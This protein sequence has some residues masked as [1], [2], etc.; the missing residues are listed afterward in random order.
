MFNIPLD[1]RESKQ[2]WVPTDVHFYG[3]KN[4]E[5]FETI[6]SRDK[7]LKLVHEAY[8]YAQKINIYYATKDF[9]KENIALIERKLLFEFKPLNT[10]WGT[11]TDPD[12][13]V[14]LIHDGIIKDTI[15][16]WIDDT[17][18]YKGFRSGSLRR[19]SAN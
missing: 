2:E 10:Y 12:S 1:F 14:T 7:F 6:F 11:K 15:K 16:K 18:D 9:S 4:N 8:E 19:G 17:N 5:F 13:E 3:E